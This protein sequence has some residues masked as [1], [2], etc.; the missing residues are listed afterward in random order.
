MADQ[1]LY[2]QSF[3]VWVIV[4]AAGLG[5]RMK[6]DIPKQYLKIHGKTILEHTLDC[7]SQH[8]Q[9][10]GIVVVLSDDDKYWQSSNIDAYEKPLFTVKGGIN[11]SDSVMQGLKYLIETKNVAEDS[12]VMVHDAARPCLDKSDLDALLAI[13]D[14]SQVGGVLATP[15]RDTMKRAEI[16]ENVQTVVAHTET[17]ENL[18][19]ALTPQMFRLGSLQDALIKCQKDDFEVTDDC[20]AMEYIGANPVIVESTKNN[21]KITN[22]SDISLIT[23]L[24]D[25]KN[26]TKERA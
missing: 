8:E 19:H 16:S 2:S 18:W 11:R 6:S 1:Q 15:V 5:Q 10:A 7:F 4:P 21:I 17:R 14:S 13:R 22:P 12:W 20:S 3:M 23:F 26:K 9:I 25:E 24:L